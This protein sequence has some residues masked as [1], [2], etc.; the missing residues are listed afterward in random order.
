LQT[1][2]ASDTRVRGPLKATLESIEREMIAEAL[3]EAR[4]NMAEAART[5]GVSHR[6]MGLRVRYYQ[7]EP[8]RFRG[9]A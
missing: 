6:I 3:K 7:I 9:A 4:G 1:A 5:L 2:E 8:T